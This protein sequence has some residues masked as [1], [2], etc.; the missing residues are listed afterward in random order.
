MDR[1]R[2]RPGH[3]REAILRL[4]QDAPRPL[5]ALELE[6]LLH[7]QGET[8][9]PNTVFR[10]LRELIDRGTIRKVMVAR[11]YAVGSGAERISLFCRECREVTEAAGANI[12]DALDDLA[13]ASG[14]SVA[15]H[16]VE[17][18][19]MCAACAG[20]TASQATGP[21]PAPPG[22]ARASRPTP[23]TLPQTPE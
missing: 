10:A 13:A 9:P 20:L 5:G 8:V 14:F 4:L 3:V 19:G 12:F 15:R 21:L 16:I 17:V 2:R 18:A 11:G 1:K 23:G 6:K 22:V 7:Q